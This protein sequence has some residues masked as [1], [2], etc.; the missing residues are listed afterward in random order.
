M[1][2]I[3]KKFAEMQSN[4]RTLCMVCH[5]AACVTLKD[6]LSA[7]EL[8]KLESMD[9][10]QYQQFMDEYYAERVQLYCS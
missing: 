9:Q 8:Q 10:Q 1:D 4:C 3:L 6:I 2:S 5:P 7:D